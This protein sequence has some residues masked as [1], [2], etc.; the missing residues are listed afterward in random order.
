MG[1]TDDK[2]ASTKIDKKQPSSGLNLW[3]SGL[4]SST[5]ATDLKTAFSKHGKVVG[6]KVVM[7]AR[8]PGSK[9]YG[10]VSM[11]STE[12][13]DKCIKELHKTKLHDRVILVERARADSTGPP[14][15]AP[16]DA[17]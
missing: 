2:A 4:S 8:T 13:A 17:H 9:C 6:A 11:G 16:K 7:N 12:D 14:K 10:Y 15:T 1:N 3:V 5:R